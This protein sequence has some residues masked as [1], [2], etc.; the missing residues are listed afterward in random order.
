MVILHYEQNWERG[1]LRVAIVFRC[2]K[3]GPFHL[4]SLC[5]LV[6][7]IASDQTEQPKPLPT[8]PLEEY[9]NPPAPSPLWGIGVSPGMVSVLDAFH[10]LSG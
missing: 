5:F 7:A 9:D 6:L 1:E 8:E 4:F 2:S 10:E 3:A